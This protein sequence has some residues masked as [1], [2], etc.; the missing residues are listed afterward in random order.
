MFAR[1]LPISLALLLTAV[2]CSR[3][4]QPPASPVAVPQ[5]RSVSAQGESLRSR[6]ATKS[7]REP[8]AKTAPPAAYVGPFPHRTNPFAMPHANDAATAAKLRDSAPKASE[9]LLG[10]VNVD[11]RKALLQ[12]DGQVW[13][14]CEGETRGDIEVVEITPS[15][16]KLRRAGATRSIPLFD[17]DHSS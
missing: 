13:A 2:G 9:R 14:A 6:P 3:V 5:M 16:V 8:A 11:G 12:V 7:S 17:R 4:E 1:P 15:H 10:F